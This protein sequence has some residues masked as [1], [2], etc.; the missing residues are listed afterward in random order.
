MKKILAIAAVAALTAGVSAYAANPFSDVSTDDWAYQA[1]SD[2]SDQGVVEGYPD[3]TFKGER[4]MTRYELAQVIARLMAREDQLNAEQKATLDKLAGEYADELANLGV[5]VS[6]LE[7][8]VGNISWSGDARMRY[9]DK[10]N[11]T[12]N[13]DGRMR[14]V[15]KAAVND[16]TYA[17]ARFVSEMNFKD[18]KDA[19]TYADQLF[20]NHGFGDFAV[21]LGRQPVTF[22]NQGGWLYGSAKGY[23]GAQLSYKGDRFGAT[24]GYGQFNASDYG[25]DITE[26]DMFFA[27]ANTELG[28]VA[29]DL[30]YIKPTGEDNG[31][32]FGAGVAFNINDFRV[33]GEYWKNTEA[34]DYD[35]AWNAGIGYGKLDLKKPGSFALSLAYNDV[36]AG[37]YFGGTGLQTDVLSQLTNKA[38]YGDADNVTFWNAMADVT[39][40]KNVYLH[41]EYA[42]DVDTKESE[43]DAKDAWNVSLNYKF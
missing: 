37:V 19:N 34:D 1:V 22:G 39:L 21:R 25:T 33:F 27:K 14:I 20:V 6:N 36:D 40:Q 31:E 42:F 2:L 32:L 17:Q 24:V 41:A 43:T 29:L 18:S 13:W 4:N 15:A 16:S 26:A 9:Q 38:T 7:K 23:D 3:G 5:R 11:D 10:S 30:N 8:K 28:P 12:D 35:T